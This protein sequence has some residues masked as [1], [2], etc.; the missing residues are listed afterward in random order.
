MQ[1]AQDKK[2]IWKPEYIAWLVSKMVPYFG[3]RAAEVPL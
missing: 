1:L 3:L 2:M